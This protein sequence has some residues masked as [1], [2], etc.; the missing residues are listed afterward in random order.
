MQKLWVCLCVGQTQ[1]VGGGGLGVGGLGGV[2]EIS[3]EINSTHLYLS[4]E[5]R[6]TSAG[7]PTRLPRPFLSN[8]KLDLDPWAK[9]FKV[10]F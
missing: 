4:E 9:D 7:T 5:G 8:F 2:Y 6:E 10:T 1:G 3:S